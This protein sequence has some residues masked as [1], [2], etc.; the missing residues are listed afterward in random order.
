M[1]RLLALV[2]AFLLSMAQESL[3]SS[4][5]LDSWEWRHPL[6][7]GN[8]ISGLTY[9]NGLFAAATG[10]AIITSPDS[11]N[12]TVH[13]LAESGNVTAM[14]FGNGTFVAVGTVVVSSIDGTNWTLHSTGNSN[15]LKGVAFG[16]GKFVAVGSN[17][18]ILISS[19]GQMWSNF[20]LGEPLPFYFTGVG[21]GGGRFVAVAG[22]SY[23]AT[24]FNG[25]D[26]A[27]TNGPGLIFKQVAYGNGT[28]FIAGLISQYSTD[29]LT[30]TSVSNDFTGV[31]FG[32]GIFVGVRSRG[33][34]AVSTDG[35]H[36]TTVQTNGSSEDLL[37]AGYA[38]GKYVAGGA[39]G[40]LHT[41]TTGTNWARQSSSLTHL[42]PLYGATYAKNQLLIVVGHGVRSPSGLV[43]QHPI[44]TSS[45]GRAW[46]R[47]S[48]GE[49]LT[50]FSGYAAVTYGKGMYV[51]AAGFGVSLSTNGINWTNRA[52]GLYGQHFG[53]AYGNDLFVVVGSRGSIGTSS[54]GITWKQ[55]VLPTSAFFFGVTYGAGQFVAVGDRS[56]LRSTDGV[57]W[58]QTSTQRMYGVTW[59]QGLFVAVGFKGA[60]QTS[61]TGTNWTSRTS[62]VTNWLLS[63]TWGH[64]RFVAVG[65]RGTII[66]STDGVSWTSHLSGTS[67]ALWGV[68][69]GP[70]SFIVTG[71][72]GVVLQSDT[73][74]DLVPIRYSPLLGFD[75]RLLGRAGRSYRIQSS[76]DFSVWNDLTTII[77]SG[78][79]TRV[80]DSSATGTP[81]RFYRVASP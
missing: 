58:T 24:S 67:E 10:C 35:A 63:V 47:Q 25:E 5:G 2:A 46:A 29:A 68:A 12:W 8:P 76:S 21:F 55:C 81:Y 36:W 78:L 56:I 39:N 19:N 16:N 40:V 37:A 3:R 23:I 31:A 62:G 14:A 54:D 33:S 79:S 69:A 50:G 18:T 32:D 26:W 20:S 51:A 9:G 27:T 52:T 6:P 30:W 11:T 34:I 1:T 66:S 60:I 45:D 64:G 44:L 38:H 42:G 41:S 17:G 65:E 72:G 71:S 74:P 75:L 28:Y 61:V 57:T 80:G 73:L 59:H 15:L 4:H 70:E 77:S 53:I 7:Q 22:S 13:P 43:E 49:G 48:P